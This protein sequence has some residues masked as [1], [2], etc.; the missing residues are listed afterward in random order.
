MVRSIGSFEV[1][2]EKTLRVR[3]GSQRE[4]SGGSI[5][6]ASC[7]ETDRGP[8]FV[9]RGPAQF[10]SRFHAEAEGLKALAQAQAVRTPKVLACIHD[11]HVAFLALEWID[12]GKNTRFS[13]ATLGE[14]LA[15]Q[16]R[17]TDGSFG[18]TC[19]NTIGA[20]PQQNRK[21]ADWVEFFRNNR[22]QPQLALAQ[23][24]GA[25]AQLLERGALLCELM[26]AFFGSYRPVASLL[27]GDLWSGN[28]ATDKMICR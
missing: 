15:W 17:V 25:R 13:E 28:W 27:H 7:V 4:V 21:C 16:H 14:Q 10:H 2:L 20:T 22:L 12:F 11:E 3:I 24:N 5:N 9:K 1:L 8:I 18:W 26:G 19:D 23:K 6:L